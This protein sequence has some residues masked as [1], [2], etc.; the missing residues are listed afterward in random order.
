MA[1]QWGSTRRSVWGPLWKRKLEF[2]KKMIVSIAKAPLLQPRPLSA[3]FQ[4]LDLLG[5]EAGAS[6]VT[7]LR[8]SPLVLGTAL[9]LRTAL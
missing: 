6:P 8:D 4:D 3:K 1:V 2:Q 5:A 9:V 7:S